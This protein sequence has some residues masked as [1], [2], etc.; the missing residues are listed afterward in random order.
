VKEHKSLE[1]CSKKVRGPFSKIRKKRPHKKQKK[2]VPSN[3]WK[4][5][6]TGGR[7]IQGKGGGKGGHAHQRNRNKGMVNG[8]NAQEKLKRSRLGKREAIKGL[9]GSR[10]TKKPP[11][12]GTR[13]I[14][15]GG[16]EKVQGGGKRQGSQKQNW[17]RKR[18][19][20]NIRGKMRKKNGFSKAQCE[21]WEKKKKKLPVE[22]GGGAQTKSC[23]GKKTPAVFHK[24]KKSMAG[25]GKTRPAKRRKEPKR[26]PL[27]RFQKKE[28]SRLLSI[29]R[30][31][32]GPHD[33]CSRKKFVTGGAKT[34]CY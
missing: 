14:G 2:V 33:A 6:F 9:K 29:G 12:Q 5:F 1:D 28:R 26:D 32:G 16:S 3:G 25:G 20:L 4:R 24:K 17:E 31:R 21:R 18:K 15:A 7:N 23:G 34:N 22:G 11:E 19:R 13:W 30:G 10:A 27:K 8:I